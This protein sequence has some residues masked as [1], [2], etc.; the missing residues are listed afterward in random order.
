MEN[1]PCRGRSKA[2]NILHLPCPS[3]VHI[4]TRTRAYTQRQTY[5]DSC[6]WRGGT[7]LRKQ[8]NMRL[9]L[10]NLFWP[11]RSPPRPLPLAPHKPSLHPLPARRRRRHR[12]RDS[13][14]PA[15]I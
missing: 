9:L 15:A 13:S 7:L 2:I 3:P 14:A 1:S 10:Y 12:R 4:R 11:H 8:F 6:E 5:A